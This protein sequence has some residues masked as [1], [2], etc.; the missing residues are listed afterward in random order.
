MTEF[1]FIHSADLHLGR[2]FG[3]MPEEVR[4]RL[5]E[6]R[7]EALAALADAARSHGAQHL[8]IAGD[9]F[10][11]ETPSDPVW[12]QALN[13]MASDPTLQW[14]II[15]GNH[16]SLAAEALWARLGELAREN[17]HLLTAA[18]PCKMAGGVTLLPTPCRRR[19]AAEDPTAWMPEAETSDGHLRIGLAHGGVHDFGSEDGDAAV[20][21]PDRAETARLDYL[22]LGD[23]HGHVRIGERTHY[24]GTPE[25]DRFRHSGCGVC[26]AVTLPGP[27]APPVVEEIRTGRFEWGTVE[28][29]LTPEQDPLEALERVLPAKGPA[30]RDTLLRLICTGWARLPHRVELSG[31]VSAAAPEFCHLEYDDGQLGTEYQAEHLDEIDSRGALRLAA[32]GLLAE[33]QDP[34]HDQE[35]RKVAEAALN[36]LYSL[37][38]ERAE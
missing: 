35:Q 33:A 29:S 15:P 11:T 4:G 34:V 37:V 22:A 1:R 6:A 25:R 26:L 31:A 16:D 32:E 2:R 9:L 18:A 23:W 10:D 13:A 8:L 3:N 24:S 14:W 30:R 5:V 38:R 17:V 19:R 20:I 36:R 7:H 12:R 27:G 21:A 28:L